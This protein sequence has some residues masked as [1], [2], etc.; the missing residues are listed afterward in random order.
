MVVSPPRIRSISFLPSSHRQ[1]RQ[2]L[3]L[4]TRWIEKGSHAAPASDVL[5]RKQQ[6]PMTEL[7]VFRGTTG[8]AEMVTD[9]QSGKK[10]PSPF[11][12]RM[13]LFQNHKCRDKDAP[14]GWRRLRAGPR[15]CHEGWVPPLAGTEV[16]LPIARERLM[17]P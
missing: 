14:Y 6:G 2:C 7:Y 17:P 13:G 4:K 16:R 1:C 9:E 15:K 12:R 3:S 11:V 8:H 5:G 10:L